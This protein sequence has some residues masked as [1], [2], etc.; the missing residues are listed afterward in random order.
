[1]DERTKTSYLPKEYVVTTTVDPSSRNPPEQY[2]A[3]RSTDIPHTP[4]SPSMIEKLVDLTQEELEVAKIQ[5]IAKL[6]SK[7]YMVIDHL[8]RQ[9]LDIARLKGDGVS[10]RK[11][12]ELNSCLGT[13]CT[14]LNEDGKPTSSVLR[15]LLVLFGNQRVYDMSEISKTKKV[16]SINSARPRKLFYLP[17]DVNSALDI[18]KIRDPNNDFHLGL[19]E[20]SGSSFSLSHLSRQYPTIEEGTDHELSTQ[21]ASIACLIYHPRFGAGV[22]GSDGVLRVKYKNG[23]FRPISGEFF[24]QAGYTGI[25]KGVAGEFTNDKTTKTHTLTGNPRDYVHRFLP[26]LV[27]KQMLIPNDFR[28]GNSYT[29]DKKGLVGF[30]YNKYSL[31]QKYADCETVFVDLNGKQVCI[32]MDHVSP[33]NRGV[34]GV[35][36]THSP[37]RKKEGSP[38]QRSISKPEVDFLYEVAD[39]PDLAGF[40]NWS[41]N[42]PL[43]DQ[44]KLIGV[45]LQEIEYADIVNAVLSCIETIDDPIHKRKLSILGHKLR[46]I[47][48]DKQL[49]TTQSMYETVD[50]GGISKEA[51]G[52]EIKLSVREERETRLITRYLQPNG[53]GLVAD[54]AMGEGRITRILSKNPML[55]RYR[56]VGIDA[57]DRYVEIAKGLNHS[58]NAEFFQRDWSDTGLQKESVEVSHCL[59]RSLHNLS[60][61]EEANRFFLHQFDILKSGGVLIMDILDPSNGKYREDR[62]RLIAAQKEFGFDLEE[63]FGSAAKRRDFIDEWPYTVDAPWGNRTDYMNRFTPSVK[64]WKELAESVGFELID[65]SRDAIFPKDPQR[66]EQNCTFVF[67]K[68][69]G[70]SPLPARLTQ[71]MRETSEP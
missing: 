3:P 12:F 48:S 47:S 29:V 24:N 46:G 15:G 17:E 4:L 65:F 39:K 2:R 38:Q 35:F 16:Q 57:S 13:L 32:L 34:K 55:S 61:Y 62:L 60:G 43:D 52:E 20:L 10:E 21:E 28:G 37:Y 30:E 66:P 19:W 27:D 6:Q 44:K 5:A 33:K 23:S 51:P 31:G 42:Y 69:P 18:N 36:N 41:L 22:R 50:N 71:T 11:Q 68:K 53:T 58:S 49:H 14:S 1:M 9:Y 63:R 8:G 70:V 54:I 25:V 7:G 40:I 64:K 67:R 26:N 56:F 59:G 45:L